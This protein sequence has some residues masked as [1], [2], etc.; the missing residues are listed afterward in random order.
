LSKV[1]ALIVQALPLFSADEGGQR[2]LRIHESEN[3]KGFDGKLDGARGALFKRFLKAMGQILPTEIGCRPAA[4]PGHSFERSTPNDHDSAAKSPP[5]TIAVALEEQ[6]GA[7]PSVVTSGRAFVAEKILNL[8]FAN[9]AKVRE[10]DPCRY[11]VDSLTLSRPP[12][13]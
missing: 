12:L 1:Y 5:K 11:V 9:D 2:I 6:I 7:P 8:A 13:P 10:S 4:T 3:Y